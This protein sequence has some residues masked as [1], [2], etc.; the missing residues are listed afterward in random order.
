[1][2][3]HCSPKLYLT[4]MR[5]FSWDAFVVIAIIMMGKLSG[6]HQAQIMVLSVYVSLY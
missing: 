1:M 6:G 2:K 3:L 5:C 4:Q